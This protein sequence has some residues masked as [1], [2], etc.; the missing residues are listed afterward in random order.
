M[1]L[2]EA[3]AGWKAA[4]ITEYHLASP[5]AAG[6]TVL[7]LA[8]QSGLQVD[9]LLLIERGTIHEELVQLVSLSDVCV[10]ERQAESDAAAEAPV[11]LASAYSPG[12]PS[13]TAN[14]CGEA[15]GHFHATRNTPSQDSMSDD[16][17]P[18][19]GYQHHRPGGRLALRPG[20]RA[21]PGKI[22]EP[23]WEPEEATISATDAEAAFQGQDPRLKEALSHGSTQLQAMA[24]SVDAM[25]SVPIFAKEPGCAGSEKGSEGKDTGRAIF[26]HYGR[27]RDSSPGSDRSAGAVAKAETKAC[28]ITKARARGASPDVRDLSKVICHKCRQAGQ[29]QQMPE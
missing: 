19:L 25:G 27:S 6:A 15:S 20:V 13:Q 26:W 12:T 14:E 17:T 2:I 5:A 8:S 28:T 16:D 11:V 10:P 21:S 24:K 1:S 3:E 22:Q 4:P 29:Q 23:K 9:D 7:Q 18:Q